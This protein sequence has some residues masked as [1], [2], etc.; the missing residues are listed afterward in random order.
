MKVE[1]KFEMGD[2]VLFEQKK[3]I[4]FTEV[5]EMV[6]I[7]VIKGI[8]IENDRTI[9]YTVDTFPYTKNTSKFDNDPIILESESNVVRKI[10]EL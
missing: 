10:G 3:T 8:I 4:S 1:T 6:N 2:I 5:E 7:G 9:K